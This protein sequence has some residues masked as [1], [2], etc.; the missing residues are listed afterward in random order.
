MTEEEVERLSWDDAKQK[1]DDRRQRT[2]TLTFDFGDNSIVEFTV[3]GL[4]V[5][6]YDQFED[7]ASGLVEDREIN[8]QKM[9]EIDFQGKAETE[10]EKR[11]TTF[12]KEFY[13]KH[14]IVDGPEGFKA[15][16]KEIKELPPNIKNGLADAID[17][18]TNLGIEQKQGF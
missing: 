14:G 12:A 13:L 15:T 10:T 11:V 17:E 8:K 16:D 18:L 7:E 6:E 1:I 3:R 4:T 2:E 5:D 9:Q